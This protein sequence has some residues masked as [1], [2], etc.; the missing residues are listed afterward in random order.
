MCL[1]NKALRR[2]RVEIAVDAVDVAGV[3]AEAT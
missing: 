3:A 1:L 2:V